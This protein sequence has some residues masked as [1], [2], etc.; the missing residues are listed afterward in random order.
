MAKTPSNM[1]RYE[2]T[3]WRIRQSKAA[4]RHEARTFFHRMSA[5]A[6][7]GSQAAMSTGRFYSAADDCRLWRSRREQ[8]T[9]SL[10]VA[11][12]CVF[13]HGI[14][15]LD[16]TSVLALACVCT[17]LQHE[18]YA[19]AASND[20]FASKITRCRRMLNLMLSPS[21]TVAESTPAAKQQL[22][23]IV[24][25]CNPR[26][27]IAAL[28]HLRWRR[29]RSCFVHVLAT[30]CR[31]LHADA[32]FLFLLA[33]YFPSAVCLGNAGN[34]VGLQ[35]W[36]LA[37]RIPLLRT[38]AVRWLSAGKHALFGHWLL[39]PLLR[40]KEL[41]A[42]LM[43]SSRAAPRHLF[44]YLPFRVRQDTKF[45][46]GLLEA[47]LDLPLAQL[48][49]CLFA[50]P[51]FVLA[52][53]ARYGTYKTMRRCPPQHR[54]EHER[55]GA[56]VSAIGAADFL[57]WS[58]VQVDNEEVLLDVFAS[59]R[60]GAGLVI[61]SASARIRNDPAFVERA[62][63]ACGPYFG[64]LHQLLLVCLGTR[65]A[66]S[67]EVEK[68]VKKHVKKHV[69][70]HDVALSS[71]AAAADRRFWQA[72]CAGI[73]RPGEFY[74]KAALRYPRAVCAF[75]NWRFVP[76]TK[77]AAPAVDPQDLPWGFQKLPLG[78]SPARSIDQR[79]IDEYRFHCFIYSAPHRLRRIEQDRYFDPR[80]DVRS[81]IA[82]FG[83]NPD[84]I[85]H[86]R[87][88]CQLAV[89]MASDTTD[90]QWRALLRNYNDA[91]FSFKLRHKTNV[92]HV[93]GVDC[94]LRGWI[95]NHSWILGQKLPAYIDAM[96]TSQDGLA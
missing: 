15:W 59:G 39:Q 83:V 67:P 62:L 25:E 7:S 24:E 14:L 31:P 79:S 93:E 88:D 12:L 6:Q 43:R 41:A 64:I 37:G 75:L 68:H 20:K 4:A 30:A 53:L 74:E 2:T 52:A 76:P 58:T 13:L 28:Q 77:A 40:R 48:P 3:R 35:W 87:R 18:V 92:M 27:V 72:L 73:L 82:A 19:V 36:V 65:A 89:L 44:K 49:S 9:E 69:E 96:T 21:S 81:C 80:A 51:S 45:V 91:E 17:V 23:T 33:F 1:E 10:A 34:A 26:E 16:P 55:T 50:C 11:A 86:M 78:C 47:G 95:I 63:Q 46:S 38:L 84:T 8:P 32:E 5:I 90:E 61:T 56:L 57:P 66:V 70:K 22:R 60:V 85:S 71:S 42:M 29:V 94:F 54:E